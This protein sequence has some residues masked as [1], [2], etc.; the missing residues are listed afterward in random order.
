MVEPKW[1]EVLQRTLDGFKT[2][3]WL[4]K[5]DNVEMPKRVMILVRLW[6]QLE[7]TKNF[8]FS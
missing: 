1:S 8:G 2:L 6:I 3:Q 5:A 7:K 4:F